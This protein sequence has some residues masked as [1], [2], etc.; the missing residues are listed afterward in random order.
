MIR[1]MTAAQR[2]ELAGIAAH[3]IDDVLRHCDGDYLFLW[4]GSPAFIGKLQRIIVTALKEASDE[5]R[6]RLRTD[7]RSM[8]K[9]TPLQKLA[10]RNRQ[11]NVKR[12]EGWAKGITSPDR[13]NRYARGLPDPVRDNP[14]RLKKARGEK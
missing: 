3:R 10:E 2:D 9:Q 5:Q 4:L 8:M 6:E 14:A 13:L 7:K 12:R 11:H 1:P